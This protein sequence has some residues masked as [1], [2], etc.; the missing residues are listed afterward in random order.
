[1]HACIIPYYNTKTKL[2]LTKLFLLEVS[3][4]QLQIYGKK[5]K[6]QKIKMKNSLFFFNISVFKDQMPYSIALI[7]ISSLQPS[8]YV[9][10]MF[11]SK[12][13]LK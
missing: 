10:K 5:L 13:S 7:Q 1:M 4:L 9:L 3:R 12:Q 2:D 8:P 11:F 6:K